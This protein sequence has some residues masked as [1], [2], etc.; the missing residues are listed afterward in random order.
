[1]L[2]LEK[3]LPGTLLMEERGLAAV[4]VRYGSTWSFIHGKEGSY[5]LLMLDKVLPGTMLMEEKSL[6]PVDV[7]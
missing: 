6:T 3:V 7:R 5:L 1:M 4:D 2:I